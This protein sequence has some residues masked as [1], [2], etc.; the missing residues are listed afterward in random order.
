MVSTFEVI[1]NKLNLNL[2]DN[3]PH[4]NIPLPSLP[5][6]DYQEQ[7]AL[8]QRLGQSSLKELQDQGVFI[9]PPI[10]SA[11]EQQDDL[12]LADDYERG[13]HANNRV[14]P[15]CSL[16]ESS[17]G[18]SARTISLQTGNLVGFIGGKA[19]QASG[20]DPQ[21]R[22]RPSGVIRLRCLAALRV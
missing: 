9:F 5:D 14:F 22:F 12:L 2:I 21:A 3:T 18:N 10:S 13:I 6:A 16:N 17:E 8:L 7:L 4:N 20:P 1:D 15:S 11:D 19:S